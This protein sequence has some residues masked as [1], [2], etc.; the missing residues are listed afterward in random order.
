MQKL[1]LP[2]VPKALLSLNP[3]SSPRGRRAP[4]EPVASRRDHTL[5][6]AVPSSSSASSTTPVSVLTVNEFIGRKK[7]P[8]PTE[9]EFIAYA[10]YLGIDPVADSDLLWVAEEALWAPLPEEWTE[11]F[12]ADGR[13]FYYNMQARSSSWLHPLEQ[14]HRDL[15]TEISQFRRQ[16]LTQGQRAS[17]LAMWR[18]RCER[19]EIESQDE[20]EAWTQHVDEDGKTFFFNRQERRSAW[21]D[22]R[23]YRCH[24]LRLQ[25][26]ALRMLSDSFGLEPPPPSDEWAEL[27]TTSIAL[28]DEPVPDEREEQLMPYC[29][30]RPKALHLLGCD[31]ANASPRSEVGV[32]RSEA[33]AYL[34]AGECVVCMDAAATHIVVPCGHQALCRGCADRYSPL[35]SLTGRL[36]CPC[37]RRR[38]EQVIEVFVPK[39]RVF[40][41]NTTQS[42]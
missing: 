24:L 27:D 7:R 11:H 13:V 14:L 16:R 19:A 5:S 38:I 21:T 17:G 12:D 2:R 22:P 10:R 9:P 32:V 35:P 36:H 34:A 28:L 29:S 1:R 31:S 4:A 20:M 42:L 23:C 39:P 18:R 8:R 30:P 6:E 33:A 26:K 37:C 3:L 41:P 15:Y 25:M 40:A